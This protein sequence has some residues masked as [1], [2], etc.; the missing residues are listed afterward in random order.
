MVIKLACN[1]REGLCLCVYSFYVSKHFLATRL[2]ITD[3]DIECKCLWQWRRPNRRAALIVYKLPGE[4][5]AL[6]RQLHIPQAFCLFGYKN[7]Y[8]YV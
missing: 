1:F 3:A 2:L 4:I 7:K 8:R 5:I 6:L